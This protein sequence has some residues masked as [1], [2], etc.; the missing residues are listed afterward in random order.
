MKKVIFLLSFFLFIPVSY[1]TS[2]A[3]SDHSGV[4]CSIG[5]DT[6][7]SVVCNDYWNDSTI[8]YWDADEC[9]DYLCP[10]QI[11]LRGALFTKAGLDIGSSDLCEA[12]GLTDYSTLEMCLTLNSMQ[13]A[14]TIS[15]IDSIVD[16]YRY[17]CF[18]DY[19]DTTSSACPYLNSYAASDGYCYCLAGYS[20][21][22]DMTACVTTSLSIPDNS[23]LFTDVLTSHKYYKAIAYCKNQNIA[24]GYPDGSF[25][26]NDKINR[27]EFTKILVNSKYSNQ[28]STYAPS[29]NCFPD[30]DMGSWYAPFVCFAKD[31]GIIDGYPDGTFQPASNI[32]V[33]EA[34]K[35][36]LNT[37]FTDIPDATGLWYQ[38][39]WDYASAKGFLLSEW[40][41]HSLLISRAEMAE[42]IHRIALD[43][44]STI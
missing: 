6:D 30:V 14:Q 23:G 7:G 21:N 3:C 20:W 19:T 39:Y 34:L 15:T 31:K 26:P 32:N 4:N 27:A 12:A 9:S 11:A 38:K 44:Q 5:P 37:N 36:T 35:I 10:A 17:V 22:S 40:T 24:D 18:E 33:V 16:S 28:L 13:N 1:A 29:G 25:K 8:K 41:F 43:N 42:L 2:G